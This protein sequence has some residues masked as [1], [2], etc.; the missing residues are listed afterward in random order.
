MK[1]NKQRDGMGQ[2][3]GTN[4]FGSVFELVCKQ[5]AALAR[6]NKHIKSLQLQTVKVRSTPNQT[7]IIWG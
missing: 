2:Y 4:S 5:V 1:W 3:L 7:E 6:E